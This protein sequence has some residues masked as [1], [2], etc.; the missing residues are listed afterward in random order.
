MRQPTQW[1]SAPSLWRTGIRGQRSALPSRASNCRWQMGARYR[2]GWVLREW[3]HKTTAYIE[4]LS[5]Q[6]AVFLALISR[7]AIK[8]DWSLP[9]SSTIHNH[10]TVI[11]SRL[12]NHYRLQYVI[13]YFQEKGTFFKCK[14]Q[15]VSSCTFLKTRN[16]I[17]WEDTL[18]LGKFHYWKANNHSVIQ[19]RRMAT[20]RRLLSDD[21]ERRQAH[22]WPPPPPPPTDP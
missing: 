3:R 19:Y 13:A 2:T 21:L 1:L 11:P 10:L 22:G 16:V 20:T 14:L 17:G 15:F 5:L 9:S 6:R 7:K 4:L 18:K 12:R 8:T